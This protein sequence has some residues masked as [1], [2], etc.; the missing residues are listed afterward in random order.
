M[1]Y[2]HLNRICCGGCDHLLPCLEAPSSRSQWGEAQISSWEAGQLP[3]A[4]C[5]APYDTLHFLTCSRSSPAQAAWGLSNPLLPQSEQRPRAKSQEDN[6]PFQG[7]SNLHQMIAAVL[8]LCARSSFDPTLI[9]ALDLSS[10]LS[11]LK[12]SCVTAVSYL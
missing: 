1:I 2:F 5:L 11:V 7:I 4:D 6:L 8:G 10:L 9:A 12:Q 3:F